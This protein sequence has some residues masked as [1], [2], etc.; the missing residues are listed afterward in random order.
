MSDSSPHSAAGERFIEAAVRMLGDNA[1]M[2][3]VAERELRAMVENAE[4]EI[5]ATSLEVAAGNLERSRSRRWGQVALYCLTA[6]ASVAMLIPVWRDYRR[7]EVA[8]W[9]VFA[10]SDPAGALPAMPFANRSGEKLPGIFGEFSAEE[11]ALLF[12]DTT[13]IGDIDQF[14]VLTDL[15][16]ESAAFYAEY[17]KHHCRRGNP[18]PKDY[19]AAAERLDPDNS[20]FRYLAAGIAARDGVGQRSLQ[21]KRGVGVAKVVPF[22][23]L[24]PKALDEAIRLLEEAARLPTYQPYR[25]KLLAE[26]L[27][28][29]PPGDDVLGRK[30][31]RDYLFE[32]QTEGSGM[33]SEIAQAVSVRACELAKAGD[34][35]GF[36]RLV[37]AWEVFCRR[38]LETEPVTWMEPFFIGHSLRI[39]AEHL[40]TAAKDLGLQ[41]EEARYARIQQT[42]EARRAA[43]KATYKNEW[44]RKRGGMERWQFVNRFNSVANPPPIPD[45]DLRAASR[46]EHAM[47]GRLLSVAGWLVFLVAAVMAAVVRFRHGKQ[48][49][50]VSGSLAGVMTW[51]DHAWIACVGV[52]IPFV[53]F[54]LL[55]QFTPCGGRPY[56]LQ[57]A[58]AWD[59]LRATSAVIVMAS[60]AFIV[61]G[62][63]LGMRLGF[64]GWRRSM[65]PAL[66]VWGFGILAWIAG[67]VAGGTAYEI[68]INVDE[69]PQKGLVLAGALACVASISTAF[70]NRNAALR[71]LTCCRAVVPA[72]VVAMLVMA[73]SVPCQHSIERYWTS[74]N[75][76]KTGPSLPAID[77]YD[78][79]IA[80]LAQAEMLEILG[81]KL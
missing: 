11:V 36:L 42:F 47:L 58:G 14:K 39:A 18:L 69:W 9:H 28:V 1:E 16:P 27:A 60:A 80:G 35:E 53:V 72:Y 67:C 38:S 61:A 57:V 26:R 20:W 44:D 40:A 23:I 68:P 78:Y 2:Q 62:R 55:E 6:V 51:K 66:I 13:R 37:N 8:R 75:H 73:A 21:F 56:V 25:R 79:R 50:R 5:P 70:V 30:L 49:R 19:L 15:D 3:V 41:E 43:V 52:L 7:L 22:Q 65:I 63:R 64:P 54:Q 17:A 71:W 31:A 24:K 45:A 34:P 48:A 10:M 12:G 59:Y 4:P 46:A 76:L 32:L 33:P 74:R 29:L 81:R 77:P